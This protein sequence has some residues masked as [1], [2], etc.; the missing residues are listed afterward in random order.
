MS[1]I[2][3]SQPGQIKLRAEIIGVNLNYI[4]V[5]QKAAQVFRVF[6]SDMRG[7]EQTKPIKSLDLQENNSISLKPSGQW[8]IQFSKC[9]LEVTLHESLENMLVI[10][11]PEH[12]IVL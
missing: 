6:W 8:S 1:R 12:P 9:Y 11:T 4:P 7:M 5:Q 3:T 10:N 2:K